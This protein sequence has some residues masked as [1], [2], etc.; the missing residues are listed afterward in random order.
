MYVNHLSWPYWCNHTHCL[1][2]VPTRT[3]IPT[4]EIR[5]STPNNAWCRWDVVLCLEYRAFEVVDWCINIGEW[6]LFG[7]V[8][9]WLNCWSN[10]LDWPN[11]SIHCLWSSISKMMICYTYISE[12]M[13]KGTGTVV[14]LHCTHVR[15]GTTHPLKWAACSLGMVLGMMISTIKISVRDDWGLFKDELRSDTLSMK[16]YLTDVD[17]VLSGSKLSWSLCDV[18]DIGRQ[19]ETFNGNILPW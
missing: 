11:P 1:R 2:L 15:N 18:L 12:R 19:R 13:S 3:H 7:Q 10:S 16:S 5:N 9:R 6:M 4:P 17:K 8:Y 14:S